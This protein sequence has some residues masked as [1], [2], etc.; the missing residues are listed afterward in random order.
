MEDPVAGSDGRA[1]DSR[2][3]GASE[4]SSVGGEMRGGRLNGGENGFLSVTDFRGQKTTV[5]R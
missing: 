2:W 5:R 3:V 4:D 1:I